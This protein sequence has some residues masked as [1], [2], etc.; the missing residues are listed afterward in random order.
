MIIL[1]SNFA[2][3]LNLMLFVIFEGLTEFRILST[4]NR[5]VVDCNNHM[6][7]VLC[8]ILPCVPTES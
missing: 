7:Y 2:V 1:N 6:V 5:V 8:H 3:N 4:N